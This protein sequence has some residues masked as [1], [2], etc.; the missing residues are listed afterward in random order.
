MCFIRRTLADL[1]PNM[2][3]IDVDL[4]CVRSEEVIILLKLSLVVSYSNNYIV[5][6]EF[7]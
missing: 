6:G 3:N 4:V 5:I 7:K 2:T 1:C